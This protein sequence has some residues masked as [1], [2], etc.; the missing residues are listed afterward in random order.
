MRQSFYAHLCHRLPCVPSRLGPGSNNNRR[1][2]FVF[3]YFY[4]SF[5]RLFVIE[6]TASEPTSLSLS[7]SP[8]LLHAAAVFHR[9]YAI[10]RSHFAVVH[11]FRTAAATWR[12]AKG[13][14]LGCMRTATNTP[15]AS[16]TRRMHRLRAA[17]ATATTAVAAAMRASTSSVLLVWSTRSALSISARFRSCRLLLLLRSCRWS[18][19]LSHTNL[20]QQP[21]TLP[22][23]RAQ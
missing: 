11:S 3:V 1:L 6:L 12:S 17:A 10:I 19:R 14:R 15:G 13:A 20:S 22:P 18:L 21:K 8:N 9:S 4:G 7:F 23:P 5:S 2:V 16:Y